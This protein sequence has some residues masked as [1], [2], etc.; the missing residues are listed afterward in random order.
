MQNFS[1]TKTHLKVSSAKW[2]PFCP[3]GDELSH[4]PLKQVTSASV[5]F[6]KFCTVS[7]WA[8]FSSWYL[9]RASARCLRVRASWALKSANS[10]L[11]LS[12]S[13]SM[14]QSCNS[15]LRSCLNVS[16]S[17]VLVSFNSLPFCSTFCTKVSFSTR[18]VSKSCS[19]FRSLSVVFSK[20]ASV[21]FSLLRASR[22]RESQSR[23]LRRHT[24]R[25]WRSP[26]NRSCNSTR[27]VSSSF[28]A[29]SRSKLNFPPPCRSRCGAVGG[30]A[31][32]SF[33]LPLGVTP[34]KLASNILLILFSS[35][36][37]FWAWA[38][39]TSTRVFSMSLT[40][41]S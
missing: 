26:A 40:R 13:N 30:M 2:R 10:F 25:S 14:S 29:V 8:R 39:R 16:S 5:A 28:C 19:A 22:T 3:G 41:W 17:W 23:L 37:I 36:S 20:A 15:L 1:F 27:S 18:T 33:A 11:N 4:L 9:R 31:L 35:S 6:R 34:F 12:L 7:S 24:P 21:L 38:T 32:M